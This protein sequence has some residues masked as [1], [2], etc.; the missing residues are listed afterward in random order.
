MQEKIFYT[1]IDISVM[2]GISKASAYSIIRRL[3]KELEEKGYIVLQGKISKAYF[4]E[5]W[6]G[7][8]K[9]QKLKEA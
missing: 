4:S 6:Y 3:N 5:K 7:L 9:E 1:A 2:L 8:N